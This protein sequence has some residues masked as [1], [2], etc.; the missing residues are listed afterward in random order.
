M[1]VIFYDRTDKLRHGNTEPKDTLEELLAAS[2]VVSL[3]VPETP[4]TKGMIGEAQFRAMKPGAYFI[5]NARGTVYDVEA[6]ARALKD[7]HLAG[8]AVDVFP[9]EPKSNADRFVSAAS[10]PG[11]RH[12]YAAC[13]RFDAGSAG[14]DRFGSGTQ[15]D[16]VFRRGLDA[17][18]RE[19]PAGAAAAAPG[20]HALHPGA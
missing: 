1:R 17:R 14:T 4:E 6:L 8:A 12:S 9:V 2:D 15:A 20:W 18:R 11:Q 19:L 5:N 16:R 7:K 3:H 13:R 10:G